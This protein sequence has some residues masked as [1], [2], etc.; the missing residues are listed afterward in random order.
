MRLGGPFIAPMDQGAVYL[1]LEGLGCLLC[2][3]AP[4]TAQCNGYGSL[5]WLLSASG[6]T[7]LSGA[8]I[9]RWLRLTCEVV[10]GQLAHRTVRCLAHIVR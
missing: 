4:D 1:H 10:V 7:G 5:D 3:G 2:A 6:G 8:P 9:D